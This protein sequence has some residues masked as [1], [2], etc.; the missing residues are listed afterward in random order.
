MLFELDTEVTSPLYISLLYVVEQN[1]D[2]K[3]KKRHLRLDR[4][5]WN[6]KWLAQLHGHELAWGNA[7][8]RSSVVFIEYA[9]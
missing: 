4:L 8:W 1:T 3:E 9:T 5:P 6:T 2:W 7:H